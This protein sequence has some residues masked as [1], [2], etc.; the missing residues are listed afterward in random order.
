MDRE[1]LTQLQRTAVAAISQADSL[2]TLQAL[3]VQYL[4]RK[5]ELTNALRQLKDMAADQRQ[6]LGG[7]AN[8][9]K[10]A[11]ADAVVTSRAAL[12]ASEQ[13][14]AVDVTLPGWPVAAGRL[15]PLSV[16]QYQLE[17]IFS[18]LGF[19]V[20]DGPELESEYFNFESLN[21]PAS[22]PARDMQDTFFIDEPAPD[23]TNRLVLRTHTSSMQVRAMREFGA[24]LR[25][26]F[27]GRVYRFEATDARHET[28]FTQVE[29]L[30]LDR[31]I[32]IANLTAVIRSF[33]KEI[34][35]RDIKL[36]LRPGYF[37]FV[38]PG[39]EVDLNCALCDGQGCAVCKQ[40]GW[41][42]FMGCG[43]VHPAVLR[44]GGID[45]NTYS[46][47][48][49]GFGLTRLVMMKYGI[50]DIRLLLNGDARFLEQF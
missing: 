29:G 37:P 26:V 34:F 32:S 31:D 48:A 36:R 41:V 27:P 16:M 13:A 10:Q 1:L 14:S 19:R 22:H 17:D 25:A 30:L 6:T 9:V 3:E 4:G 15:H 7:L 24:P 33:L 38:E 8:E 18:S 35:K 46:G 12:A 44:A 2:E 5:S 47:F 28:T 45:P 11:I 21:V 49:F 20:L 43:L 40:T 50:D 39:F 42:E 23:H